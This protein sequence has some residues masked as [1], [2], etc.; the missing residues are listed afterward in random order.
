M[1]LKYK[2]LNNQ[3]QE[4]EDELKRLSLA[5]KVEQNDAI[6]DITLIDDATYIGKEAIHD[7]IN[8]LEKELK[9]WW[10]CAC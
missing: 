4:I 10:Y 7:K 6:E 8:D 2:S 1:Q 5:Y 3:V 9:S